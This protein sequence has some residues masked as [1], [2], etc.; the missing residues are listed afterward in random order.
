MKTTECE[1]WILVDADGNHS[2]GTDAER[3]RGDYTDQIGALE[4]T[5]GF[6]MVKV[7]LTVPMPVV[8][9]L[10]GSVPAIGEPSRLQV[11]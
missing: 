7:T 3:A 6:R 9:E 10:T 8:P 11:S 5:E 1:V 2:V 4:E